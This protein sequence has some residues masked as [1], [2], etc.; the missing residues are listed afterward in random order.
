[1][2][3]KSEESTRGGFPLE[4]I[5]EKTLCWWIRRLWQT[6]SFLESMKLMPV[7]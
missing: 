4:A 2:D 7:F 5:P 1:M 3:F 6:I